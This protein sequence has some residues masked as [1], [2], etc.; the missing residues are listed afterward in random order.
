MS[1][2]IKA[3]FWDNDGVLVDTERL[4]FQANQ[5]ILHQ[6]FGVELTLQQ[7][8]DIS[9]KEGKSVFEL[10]EFRNRSENERKNFQSVRNE[11]FSQLLQEKNDE[12]L[13]PGAKET[14]E[15]LSKHFQMGIVTSCRKEHFQIIHQ[16]TGVLKN[17]DF[18]LANGDY[19][20]SKPYPDPYLAAIEK[21]GFKP[22][23]CA[24]LEDSERGVL[25]ASS[26]GLKCIAIPH[27]LTKSG[28][29]GKAYI[30][31]DK[32]ELLPELLLK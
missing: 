10:P 18:I 17:F 28:N 5:E 12:L 13:I 32:I 2:N 3:I 27:E 7:F 15:N 8:I 26:A 20:R 25:A 19:K 24:A 16:S 30:I 9:L 31:L 23:E 6:Q 22:E 4:Y 29:F 14:A 11:R 1:L 21:S